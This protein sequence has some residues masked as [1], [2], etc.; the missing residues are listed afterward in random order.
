[1]AA[2]G[3]HVQVAQLDTKQKLAGL[4]LASIGRYAVGVEC[5]YPSYLTSR[6]PVSLHGNTAMKYVI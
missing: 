3:E 6:L 4:S 1:M 2:Y 5:S